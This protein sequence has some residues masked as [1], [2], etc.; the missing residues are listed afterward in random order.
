MMSSIRSI[1]L[2]VLI[3]AI[4]AGSAFSQNTGSIAGQVSDSVGAVVAGA[5]VT[6]VAADG[7]EKQ[8]VTNDGGTFTITGLTAGLYTVRAIATGFGL[9]ENLE[10]TVTAG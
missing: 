10:V 8:A 5:T 2:T 7:K 4:T 3:S 6:A 9:Y 1:F